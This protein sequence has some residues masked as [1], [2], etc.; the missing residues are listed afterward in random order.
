MRQRGFPWVHWQLIYIIL[1]SFFAQVIGIALGYSAAQRGRK[2]GGGWGA[3]S[4]TLRGEG[5]AEQNKNKAC[6]AIDIQS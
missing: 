3:H 2:V 1:I 6:L 4:G 5:D